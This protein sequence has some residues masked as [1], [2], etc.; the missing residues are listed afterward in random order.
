MKKAVLIILAII[1]NSIFA[2]DIE[3]KNIVG[4]YSDGFLGF[5]TTE[6][7]LKADS[8]FYLK[9]VD[10][11]FPYTFQT[12]E[13]FGEFKI[14]GDRIILNPSL[15]K[16]VEK[17]DFKESEETN[18]SDSVTIEINYFVEKFQNEEFIEKEKFDFDLLTIFINKKRHKYNIVQHP[19]I[20]ICA[21][22]PRIKKQVVIDVSNQIKIKETY[23]EKIGVYSYG[24][25][26]IIWFEVK[27]PQSNKFQF[28][29]EQPIDLE[30]KPRNKVV[31]FK[32]NKAFF[33]ERNGKIDKSAL[34]LEKEKK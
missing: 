4:K 24:F 21:F 15:E 28:L 14:S 12:Y 2:Q 32:K 10:P 31:E 9:S 29:I 26:E 6:L 22:A 8:T 33:Y 18:L 5:S 34:P 16:R 19:K 11:I 27:N 7:E 30:R 3:L 1:S 17:V 13:N 20:R 23:I 25:D